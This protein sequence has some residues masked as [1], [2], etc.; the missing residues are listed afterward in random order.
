VTTDTS[1]YDV[2]PQ[3]VGAKLNFVGTEAVGEGGVTLIERGGGFMPNDEFSLYE[4][5]DFRLR[6]SRPAASPP[7]A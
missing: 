2:G 5:R 4:E 1:P 3:L 6:C 7:T